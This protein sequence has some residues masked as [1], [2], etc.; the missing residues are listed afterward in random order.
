MAGAT[1]ATRPEDAAR[2]AAAAGRP[3]A[4]GR[5]ALGSRT[6]SAPHRCRLLDRGTGRHGPQAADDAQLVAR[7][8]C[9]IDRRD[10]HVGASPDARDGGPACSRQEL[11]RSQAVSLPQLARLQL[12]G[13][14]SRLVSASEPRQ[15]PSARLLQT[16]QPRGSLQ[17]SIDPPNEMHQCKHAAHT[18]TCTNE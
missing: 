18:H 10:G 6:P 11:H 9:G 15:L 2:S 13:L 3:R 8:L 7:Q 1:S 4:A 5:A 12:Q 17:P 16:R 14:Q